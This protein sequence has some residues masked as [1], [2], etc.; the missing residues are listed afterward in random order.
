MLSNFT[1]KMTDPSKK[2]R[3][4]IDESGTHDYSDT[5][6]IKHRYLGLTGFI[7]SEKSNIDVLQPRL[8]ELKRIIANDPDELP[9]LHREDIVNKRGAFSKLN[10][11]EIEKQ[12][13]EILM[14]LIKD[15]DYAICAVVLDKKTH[16]DRY[17][18]SAFHP[19]HY[20][21]NVLLERY[22]FYLQE[23]GFKGDVLAE[24]RGK[25]EDQSLKEEYKRFYEGGTYFCRPSTIQQFLTS[26]EI[27]IKPKTKMFVG[28]EFADLLSLATKFDTLKSFGEI[29]TLNDNF[30]KIIIDNIQGKYRSSP[31]GKT[32]G[33]G[34]KLIK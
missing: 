7:I 10:N 16:L 5:D 24:A 4:Y 13:N 23:K 15:M 31:S 21:M 30:C 12:F 18:K 3:L 11:V 27:K 19:Y 8:L 25:K 33:F 9:I 20:C 28:L 6:N 26:K 34:K 17:Q 2:F 22:T 29:S 14:S 1:E 32:M